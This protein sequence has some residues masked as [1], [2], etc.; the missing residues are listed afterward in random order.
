MATFE[1][2]PSF[3]YN[4][5]IYHHEEY[6]ELVLLRHHFFLAHLKEGLGHF[7]SVQLTPKIQAGLR[8]AIVEMIPY[9]F[10]NIM[11]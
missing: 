10:L 8:N 11:C 9:E 6:E 4:H 1:Y 2:P 5:D 3:S 7:M